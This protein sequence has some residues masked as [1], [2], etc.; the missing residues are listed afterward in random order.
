[1]R[2]ISVSFRVAI[3]VSESVEARE[4][5]FSAKLSEPSSLKTRRKKLI[6]DQEAS[7]KAHS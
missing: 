6:H 1:M 4:I 2:A 7:C 5:A 3:D